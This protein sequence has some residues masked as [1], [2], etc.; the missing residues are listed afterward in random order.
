MDS[1]HGLSAYDYAARYMDPAIGRFMSVDPLA[2]EHYSISPYTYVLNNPLRFIDPFG[3][4]VWTTNDS[5][6]IKQFLTHL[7]SVSTGETS[8]S[9]NYGGWDRMSDDEYAKHNKDNQKLYL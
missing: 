4:D 5:D 3:M 7:Q 8:G 1:K 2:E 6:Q 9:F